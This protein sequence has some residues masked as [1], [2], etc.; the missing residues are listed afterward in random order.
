MGIAAIAAPL[1]RSDTTLMRR[2]P[3]RST[4][5]PPKKEA[6]TVA[7]VVKKATMPVS[8]ALP[9]CSSTNHGIATSA[10]TLPV[11]LIASER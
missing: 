4:S 9:L 11:T 5:V 1:A 6:T 2:N 3:S 10:S 8:A 7:S